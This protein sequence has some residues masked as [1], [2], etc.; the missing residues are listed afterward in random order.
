VYAVEA[1]MTETDHGS[2]KLHCADRLALKLKAKLW[3][4]DIGL[5]CFC[6]LFVGKRAS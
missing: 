4:D 6:R 3:D 1:M 5:A 2:E